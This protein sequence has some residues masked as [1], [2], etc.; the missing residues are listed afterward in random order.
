VDN[1]VIR[2]RKLVDSLNRL[3]RNEASQNYGKGAWSL[4]YTEI[5][6][7]ITRKT[8]GQIQGS[9][10]EFNP[11]NLRKEAVRPTDTTE[12]SQKIFVSGT[13]AVKSSKP[14]Q[15]SKTDKQSVQA[16]PGTTHITDR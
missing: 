12:T 5:L 10:P 7:Q 13:P 4:V 6:N 1:E 14:I 3:V 2:K 9:K 8:N 16:L 11:V 15:I